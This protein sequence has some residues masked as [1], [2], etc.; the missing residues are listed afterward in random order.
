M[1]LDEL[2]RQD[3]DLPHRVEVDAEHY[4][5]ILDV[6]K[7]RPGD[8]EVNFCGWPVFLVDCRNWEDAV[9]IRI[10]G[11][12]IIRTTPDNLSKPGYSVDI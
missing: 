12:V 9:Y 10:L 2:I 8:F 1:T 4:G 5:I 7:A 3:R 11:G 6:V